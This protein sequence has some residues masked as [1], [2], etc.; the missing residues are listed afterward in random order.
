MNKTTYSNSDRESGLCSNHAVVSARGV[1]FWFGEKELK[2]QI[3]FDVNFDINS[4]EV[5][6][7]RGQS[8]SGKTTLLTLIGALRTLHDGNLRVL[9]QEMLQAK[10]AQQVNVRRRIGFI[11]QSHNLIPHL[12]ALD[13]VRLALELKPE[14][15]PVEGRDRAKELLEAVGV[16]HRWDAFPAK[17]SGGQK[18]RVAVARALICNPELILAD[19]PTSALDGKSGREVVEK[20]VGLA[21]QKG[22]PVLMVTHDPRIL[23]F[24]DRSLDMEDGRLKLEGAKSMAVAG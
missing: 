3:L 24:A 23:D 22:V 11:F 19:E 10:T 8:G 13:N 17:L 18:Q 12:N 9:N 21:R 5:V 1:N 16:G 7:L 15:G 6:L 2:K 4:G 20:L 14:I